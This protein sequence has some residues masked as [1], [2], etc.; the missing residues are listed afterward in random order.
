MFCKFYDIVYPRDFV[1]LFIIKVVLMVHKK[2]V[3][4]HRE[5]SNN[6]IYTGHD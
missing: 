3:K 2:S 1:Y 5:N 4:P 6:N